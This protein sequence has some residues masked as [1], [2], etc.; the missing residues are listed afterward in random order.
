MQTLSTQVV[1][2]AVALALGCGG[3]RSNGE[4]PPDP[5]ERR[6]D[7]PR[8][9][10]A[11]IVEEE[12]ESE[13]GPEEVAAEPEETSPP[14]VHWTLTVHPSTFALRDLGHV[15]VRMTALND[16]PTAVDPHKPWDLR[17]DGAPSQALSMAFGNGAMGPEWSSLP[18][19]ATAVDEREG[20]EFVDTRGDHEITLHWGDQ[21]LARTTV[22]VR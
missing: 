3:G 20:V 13:D 5:S 16:G 4:A 9:G 2:G 14:S 1:L 10:A 11:P 12:P 22:H 15:Q 8:Q 21:E 19:G 6:A 17:V 7:P 18:P